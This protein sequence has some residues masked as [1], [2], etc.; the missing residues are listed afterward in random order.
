MTPA[1]LANNSM[2][3]VIKK[4]IDSII[5]HFSQLRVKEREHFLRATLDPLSQI[6][7]GLIGL[8]TFG[9][10]PTSFAMKS[11]LYIAK[12][13]MERIIIKNRKER[14]STNKVRFN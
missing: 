4:K 13:E 7:D 8:F 14:E 1:K 12:K 2:I 5:S 11:V 10:F 6:L 9:L 3:T